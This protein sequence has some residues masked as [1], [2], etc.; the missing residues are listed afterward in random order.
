MLGRIACV[1]EIKAAVK[2]NDSCA[3]T[4]LEICKLLSAFRDY[5][6]P[7]LRSNFL[8]VDFSS[9]F[10]LPSLLLTYS[11]ALFLALRLS[12]LLFYSMSFCDN[13][14]FLFKLFCY[15]GKDIGEL[16]L[17]ILTY[18]YRFTIADHKKIVCTKMLSVLA[19]C[20]RLCMYE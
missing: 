19:V 7:R 11:L 8:L 10:N 12:L 13:S 4:S 1:C 2:I 6:F 16:S 18:L 3:N 14:I 20:S 9:S 5:R 17:E 15:F